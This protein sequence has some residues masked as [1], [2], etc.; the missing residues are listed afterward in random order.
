MTETDDIKTFILQH[1]EGLESIEKIAVYNE[2]IEFVNGEIDHERA[3]EA[4]K[5]EEV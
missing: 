2:L 5:E 4:F 3:M 1:L